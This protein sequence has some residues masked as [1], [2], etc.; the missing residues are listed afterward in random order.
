MSAGVDGALLDF[1]F[2]QCVR[3]GGG[4]IYDGH[5]QF[6]AR[7]AVENIETADDAATPS[8][9]ADPGVGL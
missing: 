9:D 3:L 4:N 7:K 5:M 6:M 8:A 1:A 2:R